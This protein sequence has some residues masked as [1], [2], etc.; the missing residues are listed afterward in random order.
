MAVLKES[1]E[2]LREAFQSGRTRSEHWRRSQLKALLALVQREEDAMFAAL[3]RDLGK[4]KI[5]AYRD[6]VGVLVKSIN[7]AL[8]GL[9][10]WMA[11]KRATIPLIAFPTTGQVIPEPLGVVLLFSSWN[12]PIDGLL[13]ITS[14]SGIPANTGLALEPVIGAITAGN[15]VALKPS[16]YAPASAQFLADTIPKYLDNN[17]VKVFPGGVQVGERLLEHRW[18]K[19]FFTVGGRRAGSPRVGRIIMTAAAKHLTPVVLELGGKCPVIVDTLTSVSDQEVTAKRV[20]AGKWGPCCG[21]ACIGIDYLLVEEKFASI[22]VDLLRKTIKSFYK[23]PSNISKI[24]HRQHFMRLKKLLAEPSVASSIV[25]GGS[26][27]DDKLSFE[28]TILLDPPLDAEVMTEEIFGP[29]LPIIT[30]KKIE[31]SVAFVRERPKPL[32]IYVF[33]NDEAFKRQVIEGTSSGSVTF[34]DAIIQF[35]CDAL[36]FGGVGQ[37]GFGRYHGKYSFDTF[38]HEKAIMKRSLLLEFTFRYPPWNETK[39]KFMR[40]VY[41]FD[42]LSLALLLLGLKK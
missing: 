7:F 28:P 23:D 36:P 11:P 38:S 5:E 2:E 1:V 21:Q 27:D 41:N 3:Y 10:D 31:D 26:Y 25:H 19:I 29:I 22:M 33:T 13:A 12:F 9:R 35:A 8:D 37:S 30:L 24:V 14:D 40:A 17:A 39:L 32:A 15:A 20:V 18:D 4:H 6:E 34:N 16:E 42:Y